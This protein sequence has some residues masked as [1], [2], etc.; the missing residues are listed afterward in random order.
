MR[1][2][3]TLLAS[4]FGRVR[5]WFAAPAL[6]ALAAALVSIVNHHLQQKFHPDMVEWLCFA[7]LAS[8]AGGIYAQSRQWTLRSGVAL[9]LALAALAAGADAFQKDIGLFPKIFLASLI[10]ACAAAP[11]ACL[12]NTDSYW[13]WN[14]KFWSAAFV[15]FIG[16]IIGWLAASATIDTAQR[17][18]GLFDS[19][20]RW[21]L[22]QD[23]R[24][25]VMFAVAPIVFLSMIPRV[26]ATAMSDGEN[27]FL[28]RAV[29]A[30]AGWALSPFI[31]VYSAVL[32]I[33]AIKIALAGAL[34]DGQV[35]GMVGVFGFVGVATILAIY[36]QRETGRVHVRLLWRIW[37]F[38]LV[39]PLVL[40][41]FA[42][43]E[44]VGEY[45]LTPDRYMAALLGALCV[46]NGVAALAGRERIVRFAPAVAALALFAVS[47]GPWGAKETSVRW[48]SA[49]MREILTAHGQIKDGALTNGASA[50]LSLKEWRRW[51]A[52]LDVLKS[53][54][55][56]R[57]FVG[58]NVAAYEED[59][60]KLLRARVE[61]PATEQHDYTMIRHLNW[62]WLAPPGAPENL[63]IL[64]Y[65]EFHAP[66]AVTPDSDD[67]K[68]EQTS[69]GV[70]LTWKH[71]APTKFETR[72]LQKML[73]GHDYLDG[74]T[75]LR[76]SAGDTSLLLMLQGLQLDVEN[77]DDP[78]ILWLSA[79][80]LRSG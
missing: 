70:V 10:C 19:D 3:K 52:A 56:L 9:S 5:S 77:P 67:I 34:P 24:E 30:V 43:I 55:R 41:A 4:D 8:I 18:L 69:T 40:L 71:G 12:R 51:K 2:P 45:G 47:F 38:L 58:A 64:G 15:A 49:A 61:A 57:A 50:P 39:A 44:R 29:A 42:I 32:W 26:E 33:Y 20:T 6:L 54:N 53:Q 62:N 78:K 73:G 75:L 79:Y 72:D 68:I 46:A 7:W 31:L 28:R 63:A 65:I 36:P 25:L 1:Q 21:S 76:A 74:M 80:L 35:G 11:R 48:Q 66:K 22:M 13:I 27:D 59:A 16:G 23:V 37:P 14:E 60:E 17:L